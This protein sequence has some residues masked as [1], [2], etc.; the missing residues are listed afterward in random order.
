MMKDTAASDLDTR[1]AL[2]RDTFADAMPP[3]KVDDAIAR[4]I[5]RVERRSS[6][7][8]HARRN[9][10]IAWPFG[11]AAAIALIAI[12][13]RPLHRNTAGE[14]AT[15]QAASLAARAKFMPLVPLAEIERTSD[16]VLVSARVPRTSLSE[17][18]LPIDPARAADSVDAELLLRRDGALLAVRFVNGSGDS[19]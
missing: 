12:V 18:G 2:L 8:S 16:A 9:A 11:L 13:A 1:L 4:A 15:E 6:A 14:D 10:W 17:L 5:A 19:R 3:A 7:W